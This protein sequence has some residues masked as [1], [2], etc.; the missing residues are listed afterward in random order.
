MNK[1]TNKTKPTAIVML[2]L[3]EDIHE[4]VMAVFNKRAKTTSKVNLV[5]SHS[6]LEMVEAIPEAEIFFGW[7]LSENYYYQAKN[8]RWIHLPSAGI[9]GTLPP[10]VF[11][12]DIQLTCSKGL[13]Q[14]PVAETVFGMILGLARNLHYARDLQK[15][16]RWAFDIVSNGLTSL[17]GKTLGIIGAGNIGQAIAKR[18]KP[19]GLNVIGINQSGKKAAGFTEIKSMNNLP[20]LLKQSDIVVL[21]L[22]LTDKTTNLMGPRQFGLMKDGAI[23]INIA[24]GKVLDQN[25]L[26]EAIHSGKIYGAG[27]DVFAE[28]P[29]PENSPLW[30]MPNVL[31]A[32][33]I[34]GFVS[35]LY[36]KVTDLFIDNLDRYL[37]GKPLQGIV[38]KQ[39]GY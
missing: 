17:S 22:P 18:A 1:S 11:K 20:W 36:E 29:L 39:K 28:E 26:I 12:S 37:A 33:H 21:C 34:G 14:A 32:P 38:N 27:L 6:R 8:L 30:E 4:R 13:H 25:A 35:D 10:A 7:R 19:F 2:T 31:V 5:M 24:R 15:E 23:L 16:N 3:E 9:D